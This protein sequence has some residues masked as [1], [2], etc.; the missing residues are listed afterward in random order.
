MQPT[1]AAI[2][3]FDE[4]P[5]L[6]A[7]V[8]A[9]EVASVRLHGRA[10]AHTFPAGD[11]DFGAIED[12]IGLLVIS[13]FLY[14][15]AAVM[16]ASSIELLGPGDVL[17]PWQD[18]RA[19]APV[20]V[21]AHYR[22]VEPIQV[23]EL[24]SRFSDVCARWPQ[25]FETISSRLLERARW[26][27]MQA[28]LGRMTRVE[29]RLLVLL[30]HV[31]DRWGHVEPDGKIVCPVRLTHAVLAGA[32]A[33]RRPTVTTA[34]TRLASRGQVLKHGDGWALQGAPPTSA[35]LEGQALADAFRMRAD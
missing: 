33:A 31:A 25:V 28:A 26:L 16:A 20:P 30:W 24:G 4:D 7:G 27:A 3:V 5:D 19:E 8:P 2:N 34:L 10:A 18:D 22:A 35:Q 23:A 21:T 14:R 13:G 17:R 11:V 1:V 29:D 9:E 32:V 15:E 12:G 6:L